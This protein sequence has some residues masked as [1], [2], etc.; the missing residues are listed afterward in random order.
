M[1]RLCSRLRR[2][3]SAPSPWGGAGRCSSSSSHRKLP[4][5]GSGRQQ[6]KLARHPAVPL[7]HP[8]PLPPSPQCSWRMP[9]LRTLGQGSGR[10]M[11]RDRQ[12]PVLWPW[13]LTW[14]RRQLSPAGR[15]RVWRCPP[16]LLRLG[17]CC[18]QGSRQLAAPPRRRQRHRWRRLKPQVGRT[19]H[20][21]WIPPLSLGMPSRCRRPV[22]HSRSCCPPRRSSNCSSSSNAVGFRRRPRHLLLLLYR[23]ARGPAPAP[24]PSAAVAALAAAAA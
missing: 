18:S 21:L 22:S 3:C 13:L 6:P 24:A 2:R 1:L 23:V 10:G 12:R 11:G 16:P 15:H 7:P 14:A 9:P 19:W 20:T 4:E 17:S 5:A 8:L